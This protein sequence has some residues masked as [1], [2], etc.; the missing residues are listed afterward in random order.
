MDRSTPETGGTAVIEANSITFT[1]ASGLPMMCPLSCASTREFQSSDIA[2]GSAAL[3]AGA[4]VHEAVVIPFSDELGN[5]I[6]DFEGVV[7]PYGS[8]KLTRMAQQRQVHRPAPARP[9]SGSFHGIGARSAVC[10]AQASGSGPAGGGARPA[11]RLTGARVA[12]QPHRRHRPAGGPYGG[13][14]GLPAGRGCG[15]RGARCAW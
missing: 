7:I 2:V 4:A 9:T 1:S 11:S 6:P 5:E 13:P 3:R 15:R 8:T 10:T 12:A 14:R